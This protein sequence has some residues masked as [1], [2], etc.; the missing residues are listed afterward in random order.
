MSLWVTVNALISKTCMLIVGATS[1]ETQITLQRRT[2][3]MFVSFEL[4]CLQVRTSRCGC[5]RSRQGSDKT[6]VAQIALYKAAD[7]PSKKWRLHIMIQSLIGVSTADAR[8]NLTKSWCLT[9]TRKRQGKRLQRKGLDLGRLI[10]SNYKNSRH[11][12]QIAETN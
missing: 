7:E 1:C 10:S 12:L 9:L 4:C 5:W 2:I 8:D 3:K 11:S 6:W